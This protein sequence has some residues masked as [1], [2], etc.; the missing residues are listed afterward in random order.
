MAGDGNVAAASA[1]LLVV[2]CD[3]RPVRAGDARRVLAA[4]GI[5]HAADADAW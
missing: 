2:P 5:Q 1:R 3:P 4:G